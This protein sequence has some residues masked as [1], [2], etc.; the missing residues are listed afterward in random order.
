MNVLTGEANAVSREDNC[1]PDWF[2]DSKRMIFSNRPADQKKNGQYGWTQLWMADA[3]GRNAQL[4]YAETG[5]HIYGGHVSPDGK[6]VLFTGNPQEDG[7]PQNSG[8]PMGLMRIADAPVV[9]DQSKELRMLYPQAKQGPV[10][11]LPA[12]WEP[13]WTFSEA[14]GG[15][16]STGTTP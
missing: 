3:D 8:A 9:E 4:V 12:G 1:T 6:Y 14:P 16:N 7:D 15:C 2:P 11:T 5:R 13:C 10:L